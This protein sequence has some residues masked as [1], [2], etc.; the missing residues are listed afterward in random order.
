MAQRRI[1]F[2]KILRVYSLELG[3]LSNSNAIVPILRLILVV[4]FLDIKGSGEGEES[5]GGQ[6]N[7]E[8]GNGE[9]EQNNGGQGQNNGEEGEGYSGDGESGDEG[10]KGGGKQKG[11]QRQQGEE[12]ANQQQQESLQQEGADERMEQY[13][14]GEDEVKSKGEGKAV[15]HKGKCYL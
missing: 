2:G 11:G 9:Q 3:F 6:G 10:G 5:G 1:Q 7:G 13:Q 8:Q 15:Q 14:D 4:F 12:G